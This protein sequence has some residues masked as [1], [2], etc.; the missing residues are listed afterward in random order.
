MIIIEMKWNCDT[1]FKSFYDK[2]TRLNALMN[3]L[4][5]YTRVQNKELSLYSVP[6][7]I[8]ELLG[9]LT[10]QSRIQFQEANIECSVS[11]PVS[12]AHGIS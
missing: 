1:I 4:F 6:I 8:V 11:F 2:V 3:D 10:V 7:D 5:E 9:Q 12:K